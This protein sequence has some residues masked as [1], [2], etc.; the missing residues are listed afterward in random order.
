MSACPT[1]DG[2]R[3]SRRQALAAC[4]AACASITPA[5]AQQ[6]LGSVRFGISDSLTG[7]MNLADARAAMQVWLKRI[8]Q[9]V[10]LTLV[11]PP[12]VFEPFAALSS[13][14][15]T[16]NLDGF[17]ANIFEYRQVRGLLDPSTVIIPVQKDQLR[18][19]LLTRAEE[20]QKGITVLRGRKLLLL[21]NLYTSLAPLWLAN[22]LEEEVHQQPDSF[23]AS[24]TKKEKAN[25]AILPVFFGQ[26]D[27]CLVTAQ[28]FH[29]LCELNPQVALRL[30][31]V[32]TSPEVATMLWCFSRNA[33]SEELRRLTRIIEGIAGTPV[34]R[35]VMTLFQCDRLAVRTAEF[36]QPSLAIL[37][38]AEQ[39]KKVGS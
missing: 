25:H 16:G 12:S 23:F 39:R 17:I 33:G 29:T 11:Y 26:A 7:Q 34:G 24:V 31:P 6:R 35:Q 18:Y 13:A 15:R 5:A 3:L 38:R 2:L 36:L 28:A 10:G 4:A 1:I 20:S 14:L 8:S 22:F 32:A 21:D 19:V 9:D 30:K 27:A 37:A